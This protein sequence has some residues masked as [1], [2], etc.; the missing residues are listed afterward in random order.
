MQSLDF[1]NLEPRLT[2]PTF[3]AQNFAQAVDFLCARW[4]DFGGRGGRGG[5]VAELIK[6]KKKI[7]ND[8]IA[9]KFHGME[10]KWGW[11]AI[12]AGWKTNNLQK[13]GRMNDFK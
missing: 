2:F 7:A 1:E 3:Y 8:F 4:I 13:C 10:L 12:V 5:C 11:K 6:E 9:Q